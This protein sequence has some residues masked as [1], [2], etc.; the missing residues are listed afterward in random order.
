MRKLLT[1]FSFAALAF[2]AIGMGIAQPNVQVAD[3][4]YDFPSND[5]ENDVTQRFVRDTADISYD[6]PTNANED[7]VNLRFVGDI[8]DVSYDYPRPEHD[9]DDNNFRFPVAPRA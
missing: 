3:V 2:A 9:G 6:F 4:S 5:L 1:A 7:D 8:A